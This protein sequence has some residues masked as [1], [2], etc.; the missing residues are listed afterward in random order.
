MS[1]IEDPDFQ[2]ALRFAKS[3]ALCMGRRELTP[4]LLIA[5]FRYLI[6]QEL[7]GLNE[8][9]V[10]RLPSLR[11]ACEC[12][13]LPETD[14]MI[15]TMD[16]KFPLSFNLQQ[17]LKNPNISLAD[18]LD[19]L[20]ESAIPDQNDD[21]LFEL[22]VSKA[23][24]WARRHGVTLLN[25]ESLAAATLFAFK[26]GSF[27][28]NLSISTQIALHS[29]HLEVLVEQKQW[30]PE[31]F[32]VDQQPPV[33]LDEKS[34]SEIRSLG[35]TKLQAIVDIGSAAGH[36]I[37]LQRS[38]AF[39]EA[40]H[41]V[42]AFMLRPQVPIIQ[43][44]IIGMS[45]SEGRT[46]FD[47]GSP[48]LNS[49]FS[50]R[51]F[52]QFLQILLAGGIAE[53]L[54]FGDDQLDQGTLSDFE[55]ATKTAWDWVG[56]FGLHE[57]FGPLSLPALID[58]PG[59]ASGYLSHEAQRLTQQLLKAAAEDTR[60]LLISNWHYVEALAE[61]LISKKTLG[62]REI[63]EVLI[64]RGIT[65]WPGVRK[66]RSKAI[67]RLVRFAE[68][69]GICQT[70]EGPVRYQAGDAI[71]TGSDSEEWPIS[72]EKFQLTYLPVDGTGPGENGT[73]SKQP[74]DAAAIQLTAR[75]AIVLGEG[76]GLL[77][78]EAGDWVVDYGEGDLSLV[79]NKLFETYYEITG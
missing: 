77:Q 76:R 69:P 30:T 71:V 33:E 22:V 25:T 36:R 31:Q 60:S 11:D 78:G 79:A 68:Q 54:R 41:A 42:A 37:S 35:S 12:T 38:T 51:H 8:G 18:F 75:R 70:R 21:A 34:F 39:H 55:A 53:Q 66:V 16:I 32:A 57:D 63:V 43:L 7:E 4:N 13:E 20:L 3:I 59:Y 29:S 10:S 48:F 44:S 62:S 56:R 24:S 64:D 6:E 47:I 40:G 46:S 74:R 72:R 50:R 1:I 23:S 2:K 15:D 73:Y 58:Q 61:R 5:G 9:L 26:E 19:N 14:L 45:G 52:R 28:E 49:P 17:I 65:T 27:V 67:E